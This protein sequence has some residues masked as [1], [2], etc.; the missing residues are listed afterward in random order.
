MHSGCTATTEMVSQT[1]TVRWVLAAGAWSPAVVEAAEEL[2]AVWAQETTSAEP[3]KETSGELCPCQPS[4]AQRSHSLWKTIS[5]GPCPWQ[6]S[7]EPN[8]LDPEVE[9]VVE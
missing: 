3:S 9:P 5:A 7:N 1:L 4:A 6:P 8:V 2:A